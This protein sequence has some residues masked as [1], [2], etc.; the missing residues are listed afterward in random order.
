VY[1]QW[2]QFEDFSH[3]MKKVEGVNQE[4]DTKLGWKAQI[5]WSH[6]TWKATI[7]DQVR[8]DHIVWRS[9]GAKGHVDGAITFHE[10]A[11]NL[12]RV[13]VVLEYYPQ[14]LFERTGNIWRAQ[15]RRARLELKHFRRH[16]MTRVILDPEQLEG[17]HGEIHESEVTLSH[18]DA[19]EEERAQEESGEGEEPEEGGPQEGEPED[20]YEEGEEAEEGEPE[21]EYE[22]GEEAEEG[23]PED[24]Y[25]GEEPEEPE[26]AAEQPEDEYEEGEEP[27]ESEEAGE[28]PADELEGEEPAEEEPAEEEPADESAEEEPE[29]EPEPAPS[30][31]RS[32]GRARKR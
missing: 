4:E 11:P 19:V 21:D 18:E 20:E 16:V 3:F 2:T 26:E 6:R 1:D 22:E 32:R 5:F 10:L 23:E 28:Q 27:A 15:G 31:S 29:E 7:L 8:N 9:E 24:E 25:E 30:R 14:G 13:L 12:T 17:W